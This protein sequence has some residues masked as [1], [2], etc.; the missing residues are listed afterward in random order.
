MTV[1]EPLAEPD[2]Q[3]LRAQYPPVLRRVYL[4]TACKGI[5]SAAAVDAVAEHCRFLRECP[6]DSTTEDTLI[7]LEQFERARVAAAAMINADPSEIALVPSTQGGLN[8][9]ADAVDWRDGDVVLA[10]DVE[11]VGTVMPWRSLERRGV[12]LQFVPHRDGKVDVA[13]LEASMD[14]RTRAVVV[15]SVQ[16]VNGYLIDLDALTRVCRDRGVL[17]IVDGVQHVGPVSLDV[18]ETPVDALAVGG[19]KW[20]CAPFGMG[21]LYVRRELHEQLE[22]SIPGYMTTQPPVGE[23]LHYLENPDRLPVDALRFAEDARKFELGAIG[24]STA[25]AGLAAALE[26]LLEIGPAAIAA[27]TGQLVRLMAEALEDAGA[28]LATPDGGRGSGFLTFRTSTDIGR[29]REAVERLTA[30]GVSAS[31]RFTTGVGGIRVS[32]YFYNDESDVDRL[33]GVVRDLCRA[34]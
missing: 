33:A 6:G 13:D 25:A 18:R 21:F 2:W 11:F 10:P 19:H 30:A 31:L 12:R 16:E 32:P 7:A 14:A 9:I 29:E 1:I 24:T 3:T 26:T 20:L 8:A 5:P 28:R 34:G 4:D 15:S 22:P 23:W 17:C 27:R